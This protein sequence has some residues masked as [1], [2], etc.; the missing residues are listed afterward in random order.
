MGSGQKMDRE[1]EEVYNF[2]KMEESMKVFG[3]R[4]KGMALVDVY[5]QMEMSIWGNGRMMQLMD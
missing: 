1:K 2:G 5:F 4:I 3:N